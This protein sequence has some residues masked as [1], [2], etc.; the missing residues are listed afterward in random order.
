MI[1]AFNLMREN[2]AISAL[3]SGEKITKT[4]RQ[5]RFNGKIKIGYN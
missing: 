4:V 2:G 3:L 1:S 5:H